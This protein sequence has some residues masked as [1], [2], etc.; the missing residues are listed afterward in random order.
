MM[1]MKNNYK[2]LKGILS[3]LIKIYMF[4]FY[5]FINYYL[6]HYINMIIKIIWISNNMQETFL[7]EVSWKRVYD[8]KSF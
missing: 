5:S 4:F 3:K 1:W 8:S 7:L 6:S 2:T